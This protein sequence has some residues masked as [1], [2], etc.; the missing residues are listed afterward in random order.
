MKKTLM[1]LMLPMALSMAMA[2][3]AAPAQ[4]QS[5]SQSGQSGQAGSQSSSQSRTDQ[6]SSAKQHRMTLTGCLQAGTEPNTYI[7]SNV[8]STNSASKPSK[9]ESQTP[10]EMARAETSYILVPQAGVDISQH[11]GK[12]VRVT[13]M[14]EGQD[15]NSGSG[16]WGSKNDTTSS[17]S[18]SSQSGSQGSQ[19]GMGSQSGSSSQMGSSSNMTRFD[20][21]TIKQVS[22]TCQ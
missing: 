11:V 17:P 13:G 3:S 10:G 6:S 8:S 22:S 16:N 5:G 1:S 4:D 2:M 18:Q 14:I 9:G 20:V 7:L 19:S 15:M 12:R 21:K